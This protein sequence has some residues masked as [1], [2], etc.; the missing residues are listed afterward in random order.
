VPINEFPNN[1]RISGPLEGN[2]VI[3]EPS[4][5]HTSLGITLRGSG[6]TI[7][8]GKDC[9][10]NAMLFAADGASIEIGDR[11][12]MMG[13]FI[14]AHEG[15]R[16]EIGARCLFSNNVRFRPSDA[17]KI[18][19]KASGQ[20]INDPRPII[21]GDDVWI[22]EHVQV[23]KGARIASGSIVGAVSL[24]SGQF[25]EENVL[26][27]GSPARVIRTGVRWEP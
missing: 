22:G 11:T 1:V 4:D 3:V 25:D 13:V 15:S 10:L 26:I 18:F 19:D 14:A 27:V 21:I 20:R 9:A 8:V 2:T 12:G 16:V 17:H 24:I 7:R 23:V 5:R 6:N